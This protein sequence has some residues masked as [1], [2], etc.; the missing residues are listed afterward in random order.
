MRLL[1]R[2]LGLYRMVLNRGFHGLHGEFQRRQFDAINLRNENRRKSAVHQ[3]TASNTATPESLALV[4]I[5][6]FQGR[7]GDDFVTCC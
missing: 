4:K 7:L 2:T 6:I 3:C 5:P 1:T